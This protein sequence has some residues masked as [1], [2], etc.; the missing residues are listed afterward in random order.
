[1]YSCALYTEGNIY[2]MGSGSVRLNTL[3]DAKEWIVSRYILGDYKLVDIYNIIE[4]TDDP[5]DFYLE[6]S[7]TYRITNG[8]LEL[9]KGEVLFDDLT[10]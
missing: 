2:R 3:E 4:C 9:I 5:E 8:S 7:S 6:I 1:M 10:L